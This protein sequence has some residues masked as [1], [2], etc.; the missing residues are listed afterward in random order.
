M[1]KKCTRKILVIGVLFL[2]LGASATLGVAARD[3][4]DSFDTYTN[5]QLLDGGADDGG[6]QGWDNNPAA[7]GMVTDAQYRSGPYS[8]QIWDLSDNV[9]LYPGYTSG[10]WVYTAYQYVPTDFSGMTY[11][12]LLSDYTDGAGQANKWAIQIHFD[13]ATNMIQSEHGGPTLPLLKGQ[14]VELRTEIDLDADW[15][16]FYYDGDLLEEKEWT[17]TINNNGAGYLNISAVDLFANYATPVYYDDMSLVPAG[18]PEPLQCDAGGPYNGEVG[19]PVQFAGSA[20]GGTEP[21]TWAWDFG[22]GNT[23][24]LEDP[25]HAYAEPGIYDVTLTVTDAASDTATDTATANIT[26]VIL[27]P[28]LEI[29][30][31]T[32]GFGVKTS[33]KNTGEAAATNVDWE[34]A[35]DGK[36]I[37]LGKSTTNTI[38]SLAVG[39]DEAIKSKLI[40]GIGKTNIVIS[41]TCDEGVTAEVTKTALVLGPFV[42]SVK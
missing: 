5:G 24:T 12:I 32:G 11:F 6:W 41:A 25:T 19:K 40:F 2:C 20:S 22:D 28:V 7:A 30:D 33:V 26:E 37:F 39:A 13:S 17:A 18:Q 35:L 10:Q 1:E 29:G 9:H 36:L 3:W 23:S 27:L 21:Y 34:I 31:V 14:W 4:A 15:F 42:L 38:A 16:K 8:N